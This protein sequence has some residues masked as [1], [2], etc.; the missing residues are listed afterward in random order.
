[1]VKTL[2]TDFPVEHCEDNIS[3][4]YVES[5]KKVYKDLYHASTNGEK[6]VLKAIEEGDN[7]IV[8]S[9]K[10][11]IEGT[12]SKHL[13]RIEEGKSP[14]VCLD[15]S[16][17]GIIEESKKAAEEKVIKEEKAAKQASSDAVTNLIVA[18][19]DEKVREVQAKAKLDFENVISESNKKVQA[20]T[21]KPAKVK[22]QI[23]KEAEVVVEKATKELEKV[24]EVVAETSRYL[25]RQLLEDYKPEQGNKEF[26]GD[27]KSL[28]TELEAKIKNLFEGQTRDIR[29][30]AEM[31]SGGGGNES[32][33]IQN[34]TNIAILS[35]DVGEFENVTVNQREQFQ[36]YLAL[37]SG[38]YFGGS[39]TTFNIPLE[40]INTYLDI[41]LA[42]YDPGGEFDYRV[43]SMK[44][45]QPSGYTGTG[46]T[47]D[48]I[49]FSLEGLEQTSSADVRVSMSFDPDEDGGRLDSRLLFNRHGGIALSGTDFAIEASAL[50]LE[51]GADQEYAYTPDI[52]F[53]IGDTIDTNAPGDAGR[54][55]FQIKSDVPGTVTINEIAMFI[56]K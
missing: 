56:Q 18:S 10:L 38:I 52:K 45:A 15:D 35:A 30:I 31:S 9:T 27:M 4:I 19:L 23:V 34:A 20:A 6:S 41:E 7:F 54:V 43:S 17:Y 2:N 47:G 37:L 53:F 51:S 42:V 33:S 40:S 16:L 49:I 21:K 3:I 25:E 44:T 12:T 32:R 26:Q 22:E 28:K 39:A 24:E 1:M 8:A 50:A 36:G 14:R 46:T 55:R 48:P 29:K 11:T 13:V 5:L